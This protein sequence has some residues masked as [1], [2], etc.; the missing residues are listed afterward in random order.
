MNTNPVTTLLHLLTPHGAVFYHST[1]NPTQGRTH[2]SLSIKRD[3]GQM[4]HATLTNG[5]WHV[6]G[7]TYPAGAEHFVA[8]QLLT[9]KR[10]H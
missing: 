5:M 7:R 1:A 2:V 8:I 9:H 3:N 6:A 10:L 4:I